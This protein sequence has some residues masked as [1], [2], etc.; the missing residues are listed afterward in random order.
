METV[1]ERV[2][3]YLRNEMDAD[4]AQQFELEMM[5]DDEL[6]QCYEQEYALQQGL[7]NTAPSQTPPWHQRLVSRFTAWQTLAAAL[8]IAVLG[9]SLGIQH[10][11]L[12]KAR[13]QLTDWQQT[14]SQVHVLT[15]ESQRSLNSSHQ[16]QTLIVPSATGFALIE[17]DVSA[18]ADEQYRVRF[19]SH[20]PANQWQNS[21]RDTRGYLTLLIPLSQSAPKPSQLEIATLDE[22]TLFSIKLQYDES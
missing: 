10:L 18:F 3:R 8:L 14:S 1:T 5:D 2:H 20:Q 4:Q 21:N 13:Q 17:V 7:L 19:D 6:F 11:H 12:Q 22:Q 9:V 16:E 15:I